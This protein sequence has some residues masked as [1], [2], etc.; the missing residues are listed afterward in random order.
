MKRAECV[1]EN[2]AINCP[3][4]QKR[5]PVVKDITD[6]INM[7]RTVLEKA[8]FAEELKKEVD[9]LLSCTGYDEAS[10]DC[11]SCHF[12]ADLRKKTAKLIAKAKKL[13]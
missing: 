1:E 8:T 7:A 9:V 4:F 10:L 11:K 5:E 2:K 3:A 6:R 13:A 12:I